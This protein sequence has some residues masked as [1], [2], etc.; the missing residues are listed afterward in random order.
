MDN[1][2]D[3]LARGIKLLLALALLFAIALNFINVIDRYLF[4]A[5]I[6]WADE[7]E[8][9]LVVAITFLGSIAVSW[10]RQHLRMDVLLAALPARVQTI[11]R[12]V[13]LALLS[14]LCS[15]VAYHSFDY[16]ARMFRIGRASDTAGLPL[17]I[18]HAALVLGFAGMAMIALYQ[19]I[20]LR[21]AAR[22]ASEG[23]DSQ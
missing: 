14:G 18:V 10:R 22:P 21:R 13:E 23:G 11:I 20:T 5:S 1:A 8:I 7:I 4:D 15:F 16:T 9:Y 19:L 2:L 6:L 3:Q 12:I 17:W